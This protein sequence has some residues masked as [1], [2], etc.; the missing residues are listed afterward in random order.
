[1]PASASAFARCMYP[2]C[3]AM[4][5]C[6]R[7]TLTCHCAERDNYNS[8]NLSQKP[9]LDKKKRRMRWCQ[10]NQQHAVQQRTARQPTWLQPTVHVAASAN[11]APACK[12][13]M[14]TQREDNKLCTCNE[15]SKT[16]FIRIAVHIGSTCTCLQQQ[17][18]RK[19]PQSKLLQMCKQLLFAK[20]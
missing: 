10:H 2:F 13:K 9:A 14:H 12:Q 16:D 19:S 7:C 15:T 3:L 1:M 8:V 11:L 5:T 6:T 20:K 4:H 17:L 18:M